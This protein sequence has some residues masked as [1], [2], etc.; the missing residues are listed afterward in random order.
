MAPLAAV[1]SMDIVHDTDLAE[2]ASRK[3]LALVRSLAGGHAVLC[4]HGD[5]I[6]EVLAELAD[7]DGVDLG[8]DP[9][10]QKGAVWQLEPA[11]EPGRFRA[12]TY[13]RPTRA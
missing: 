7:E 3:A 4:T 6:P 8:P 9:R 2:G 12:A 13:L 10:S 11:A 5:V 1:R